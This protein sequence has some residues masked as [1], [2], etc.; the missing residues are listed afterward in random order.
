[1]IGP[2]EHV[3]P[4]S[5]QALYMMYTGPSHDGIHSPVWL[6]RGGR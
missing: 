1:M 5:L 3:G 2:M 4:I 6:A